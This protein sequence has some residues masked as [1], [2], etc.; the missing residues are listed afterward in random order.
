MKSRVSCQKSG[1]SRFHVLVSMPLTT[2]NDVRWEPQWRPSNGNAVQ[3]IS[4][5]IG[6][7]RNRHARQGLCGRA[8]S[9]GAVGV[10][11]KEP[12]KCSLRSATDLGMENRR[13]LVRVQARERL[14]WRMLNRLAAPIAV[15]FGKAPGC[16]WQVFRQE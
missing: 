4:A 7:A 14:L 16:R 2:R 13:Q 9:N 15:H 5:Q 1:Y 3:V 10:S 8:A 6:V 11:V 12:Q